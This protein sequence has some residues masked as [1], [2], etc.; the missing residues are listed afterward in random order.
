MKFKNF[1]I[2]VLGNIKN[3]EAEVRSMSE[4]E[5]NVFSTKGGDLFIATFTS[6]AEVSHLVD[7][8]KSN[9]RSFMERLQPFK[10]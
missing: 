7:F 5:I 3:V 1:C 10:F 4:L 2:I 6:I 8:F 9:K